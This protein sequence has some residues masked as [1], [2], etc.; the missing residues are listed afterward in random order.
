MIKRG[1]GFLPVDIMKSSA[2]KFE[3]E[4]NNLRL[5]FVSVPGLGDSVAQDIVMKRNE[6][7]FTSKQDV[8]ERTRLNKT[9]VEKFEAMHA[10]GDLVDKSEPED[11]LS[12]LFDL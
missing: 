9:L 8:A 10:F 2:V 1:F 4:G 11:L 5:P 7:M 12:G 6:K 3:I